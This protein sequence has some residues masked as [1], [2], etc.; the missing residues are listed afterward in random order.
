MDWDTCLM[1]SLMSFWSLMITT[2]I[3]TKN[4]EST[5][6]KCLDSIKDTGEIIIGDMGS[7]DETINICKRYTNKIYQLPKR[8][9]MADLRNDLISC[10]KGDRQFYLEPWEA[11]TSGD[12]F[13]LTEFDSYYFFIINGNIVNKEVRLWKKGVAQF[14]GR[15][16]E[17]IDLDGVFSNCVIY[18]SS[19]KKIDKEIIKN[20]IESCPTKTEPY[21]YLACSFLNEFN[22]NEFLKCGNEYLFRETR[23]TMSSCMIKYYMAMVNCYQQNNL[24]KT[25]DLTISCLETKP[26]MAE[27]WCMLGDAFYKLSRDYVKAKCFYENAVILGS[28]RNLK[29]SWPI[30][31][32]KYDE[33]PKKMISSC[34]YLLQQI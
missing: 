31:L 16:F 29:D 4:N 32:N 28:Q 7:T 33:Y 9:N 3:I 22:Y 25:L 17:S 1:L 14:D 8:N 11:L 18:S 21:Y 34:N 20:W 26:L 2:H 19:S 15:V 6:K 23:Q 13:D 5:I 24:K 30:D 12:I 10:S 27:F